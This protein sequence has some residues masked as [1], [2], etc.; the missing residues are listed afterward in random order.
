MIRS[1]TTFSTAGLAAKRASSPGETVAATA[2]MSVY[3]RTSLA[4]VW[5]S[6]LKIGC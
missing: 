3:F 6:S 2:L 1:G 4:L 5:L